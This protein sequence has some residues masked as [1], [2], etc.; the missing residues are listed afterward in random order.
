MQKK[1]IYYFLTFIIFSLSALTTCAQKILTLKKTKDFTD[2]TADERTFS[3]LRDIFGTS[4]FFETGTY[5]GVS[6]VKFAKIFSQ[7]YT[8]ELSEGLYEESNNR[9]HN[10]L[11]VYNHKGDS[12]AFLQEMIPTIDGKKFIFLDAHGCG[13]KSAPGNPILRELNTLKKLSVSDCIIM[14]DDTRSFS[15]KGEFSLQSLC[16]LLKEINPNFTVASYGDSIIAYD[17]A[18]IILSD[19]VRACTTSL[20]FDPEQN[21]HQTVLKAEKIIAQATGEE[22]K[23]ILRLTFPESALYHVWRGLIYLYNKEY[24]QAEELFELAITKGCNHWRV[25]SYLSQAAEKNKN[26]QKNDCSIVS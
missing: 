16:K 18:T 11:N 9:L 19:I 13:G 8:V 14:I 20:F 24:Q 12:A 15:F 23:A 22:Q 4:I 10:C 2:G 5:S 25:I 7:V 6:A 21:D 26:L 3:Y 1:H 17:D